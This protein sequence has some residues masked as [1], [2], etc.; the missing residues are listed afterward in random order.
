MLTLA[1]AMAKSI[2]AALGIKS[3]S[4]VFRQIGRYTMDGLA[5]GVDDRLRSVQR[6]VL[7][8]AA[9]V[10]DPFG[11]SGPLGSVSVTSGRQTGT[12]GRGSSA[13]S[14]SQVN[15][16]TI[17]EVGDGEATA[18]RILNRLALAGGGL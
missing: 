17:N 12:G 14:R 7:G 15:N 2:R 18:Q 6:S 10:T 4:R 16:I 1:R 5:V 11:G 3:P 8:A 9:A 13:S